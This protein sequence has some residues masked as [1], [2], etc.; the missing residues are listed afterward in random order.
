MAVPETLPRVITD[1]ADLE[2]RDDVATRE[3]LAHALQTVLAICP[4]N[5][6]GEMTVAKSGDP[7]H[8]TLGRPLIPV[9]EDCMLR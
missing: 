9:C 3:S 6:A 8:C 1:A 7:G 5:P 4:S 2:D